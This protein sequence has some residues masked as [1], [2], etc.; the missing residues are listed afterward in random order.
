MQNTTSLFPGFH[1][2]TLRRKPRSA[3]QKLSDEIAK[4]KQK[5]FSQLGECFRN[6]IPSQYLRPSESGALS[7]RRFFSKENTFWAFFS[8]VLGDDGGCQEVIRKL[9]P[10]PR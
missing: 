3:S 8:Q 10:L 9:K 4:L 2:Q 1:L 7:R 5:T 6:F